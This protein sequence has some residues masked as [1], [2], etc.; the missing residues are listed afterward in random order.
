MEERLTYHRIVLLRARPGSEGSRRAVAKICEWT[1]Q[2][3]AGLLVFLHGPGVEHAAPEASDA[4]W[5]SLA[6]SHDIGLEV[7][8][9]AWQRRHPLAPAEPWRL[10]SLVTFWDRLMNARQIV[11]FG[12]GHELR[13][14]A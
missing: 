9:A 2:T 13:Q 3:P 6:G 12:A 8:S 7:C 4:D 1:A 10:S 5:S 14:D 11:C